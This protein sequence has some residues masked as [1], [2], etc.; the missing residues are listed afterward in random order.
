LH[1]SLYSD[2]RGVKIPL[3]RQSVFTFCESV[4]LIWSQGIANI[5]VN[6]DNSGFFL[7]YALAASLS[8]VGILYIRKASS[9]TQHVSGIGS[10]PKSFFAHVLRGEWWVI[11]LSSL[12]FLFLFIILLMKIYFIQYIRSWIS[13]VWD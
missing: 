6:D 11:S 12:L 4:S 8:I 13:K 9:T 5:W 2:T 1:Y 10:Y 7:P 3:A